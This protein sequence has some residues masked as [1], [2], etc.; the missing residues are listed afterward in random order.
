M[1]TACFFSI[2]ILAA[3]LLMINLYGTDVPFWD[4]W[5][6]EAELYI[7]WEENSLS[8]QDLIKPHVQH[9]FAVSRILRIALYEMLGGWSPRANMI[10]QSFFVPMIFLLFFTFVR[11]K[12]KTK[13]KTTVF[14]AISAA[15][16][17][18]PMYW[19]VI[20]LGFQSHF[21]LS[22][23]FGLL[24]IRL[25]ARSPDITTFFLFSLTGLVNSFTSASNPAPLLACL[26]IQLIALAGLKKR[27]RPVSFLMI[28]ATVALLVFNVNL[29]VFPES[30]QQYGA[31]GFLDLVWLSLQ[32]F[33]WPV[34]YLG[35]TCLWIIPFSIVI[36]RYRPWTFAGVKNLADCVIHD[37]T[38]LALSGFLFWLIL[39][40]GSIAWARGHYALFVSRYMNIY[41]FTLYSPFLLYLLFF[42]G[43]KE[44][45]F[46]RWISRILLVLYFSLVVGWAREG[47]QEFQRCIQYK[48]DMDRIRE[49]LIT[50]LELD[51]SEYLFRQQKIKYTYGAHPDPG[52]VF[53]LMKHPALRGKHLWLPEEFWMDGVR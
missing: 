46:G 25:S 10:F 43:R 20:L 22:L 19:E 47:G 7:K 51:D 33:S 2:L 9:R 17:I 24:L 34:E 3:N 38:S 16:F 6:S 42:D 5:D 1:K 11:E 50:A 49:N 40:I 18:F 45:Q 12:L 31:R 15:V 23:F 53:M 36:Y 39:S 35:I 8:L 13:W 41:G 52:K 28:G 37:R 32:A 14:Y 4:Q 48:T 30:Q 26:F 27:R 44:L 21:Y 29:L